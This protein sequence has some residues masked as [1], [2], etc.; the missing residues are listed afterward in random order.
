MLLCKGI[1]EE[2]RQRGIT[3]TFVLL[4][5]AQ[6]PFR[7]SNIFQHFQFLT[8]YEGGWGQQSTLVS[9]NVTT[10]HLTPLQSLLESLICL[11]GECWRQEF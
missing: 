9:L 1:S 7:I 2:N 5:L 4:A 8:H 11:L 6:L 3:V 10:E